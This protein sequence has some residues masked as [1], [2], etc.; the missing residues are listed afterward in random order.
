MSTLVQTAL[1]TLCGGGGLATRAGS[2][3]WSWEEPPETSSQLHAGAY[4]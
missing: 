1:L 3:I 4:Q 2:V